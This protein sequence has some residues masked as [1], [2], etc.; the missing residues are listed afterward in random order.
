MNFNFAQ[1]QT[2]FNYNVLEKSGIIFFVKVNLSNS[3][4]ISCFIAFTNKFGLKQGD[5]AFEFDTGNVTLL[6]DKP[7]LIGEIL[8]GIPKNVD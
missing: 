6:N 3:I 8:P 4:L 1:D 2:D 5:N 7:Y